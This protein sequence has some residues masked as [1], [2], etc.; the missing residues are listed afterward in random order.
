MVSK[1][2]LSLDLSPMSGTWAPKSD[3]R[4]WTRLLE[5]PGFKFK[6]GPNCPQVV[7]PHKLSTLNILIYSKGER[8]DED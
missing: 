6:G 1:N 2:H 4:R 8:T 7:I 5:E 3:F